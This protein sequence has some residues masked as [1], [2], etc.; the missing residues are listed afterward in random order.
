MYIRGA[1]TLQALRER[2]GDRDFF[3]LLRRWYADNRDGNVTT[4]QFT[5]LAEKVSHQQLD[6]FFANWLLA[7]GK[8]ERE[9]AAAAAS[10]AGNKA[11][12]AV[13]S[14]AW[15]HGSSR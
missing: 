1:L 7:P 6:A 14:G 11:A 9:A 13:S 8:P 12:G 2:I 5:A 10:E 3:R 15:R 4:A